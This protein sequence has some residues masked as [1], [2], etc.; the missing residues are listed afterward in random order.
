MPYIRPIVIRISKSLLDYHWWNNDTNTDLFETGDDWG[1]DLEGGI[2]IGDY[3]RPG[4]SL[5]FST[6]DFVVRNR[7]PSRLG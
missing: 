1:Y 6:P 5:G 2:Y 3:N 4:Y 7:E